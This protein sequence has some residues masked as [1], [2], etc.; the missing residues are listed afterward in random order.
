MRDDDEGIVGEPP[1]PGHGPRGDFE[2]VGDDRRRRNAEP[3]RRDRV[4]QT[5]RRAAPSVADGRHDRVG[6]GQLGEQL[7]RH[8]PSRIRLAAPDDVAD[9]VALPQHALEIVEEARRADLGI[10]DEPH[11]GAAERAER[12]RHARRL[13]LGIETRVEHTDGHAVVLPSAAGSRM[14]SVTARDFAPYHGGTITPNPPAGPPA[15]TIRRSS[16][17]RS[18]VYTRLS[19]FRPA[20]AAFPTVRQSP[21]VTRARS[22]TYSRTS[23]FDQPAAPSSSRC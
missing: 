23:F 13:A 19:S 6:R 11:G 21:R 22:M 17:D 14:T 5:A 10:V 9:P 7:P 4:V 18:A 2:A 1:G 16:G 20:T 8:R 12:G 3:L 15:A